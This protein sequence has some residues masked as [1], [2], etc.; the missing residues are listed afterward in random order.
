MSDR[1]VVSISPD[2]DDN[3]DAYIPTYPP[4][5]NIVYQPSPPPF[6]KNAN[7]KSLSSFFTKKKGRKRLFQNPNAV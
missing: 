4:L 2:N 1:S 5:E 7:Q 6:T 3:D